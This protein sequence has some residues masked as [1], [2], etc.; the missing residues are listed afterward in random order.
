MPAYRVTEEE[1][2]VDPDYE[3][4]LTALAGE[5]K[6]KHRPCDGCQQ[7]SFCDGDSEPEERDCDDVFYDYDEDSQC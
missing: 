3:A 2:L 5:C 4:W 6:A 1:S 7:G